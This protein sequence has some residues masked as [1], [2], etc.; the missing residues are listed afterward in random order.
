[1]KKLLFATLTAALMGSG[2]AMTAQNPFNL[3]GSNPG[4]AVSGSVET[5]SLPAKAQ[6]FIKE[7]FPGATVLSS[8]RNFTTG[9]TEV[10]LSNG[11]DVEF[12]KSGTPIEIDAG[13]NQ[14]LSEAIVKKMLPRKAYDELKKRNQATRVESI[15]REGNKNFKVEIRDD[16][17]PDYHFD[18]TGVL[19]L[20]EVD[21]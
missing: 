19:V 6:K 4:I 14:V 7:N 5:S 9:V 15:E 16:N 3:N 1:M 18:P 2:F 13:N 8:E 21:D 12:N 10:A 11:I 20:V 17:A